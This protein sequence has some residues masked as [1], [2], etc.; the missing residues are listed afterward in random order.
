MAKNELKYP[1]EEYRGR[2]GPDDTGDE[3]LAIKD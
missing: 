1:A 2:Y 3:G